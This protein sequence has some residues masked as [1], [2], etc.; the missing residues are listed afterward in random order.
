MRP[1]IRVCVDRPLAVI[2]AFC[3]FVLAGVAAAPNLPVELL[4]NLKSPQIEILTTFANASAQEVESLLTRPVEEAVSA[5]AG[6]RSIRSVSSEGASR[7]IL[8]F[9]WGADISL[10]SAEVREKL[11]LIADE[12]PKESKLP[13][14]SQV[15]ATEAPIVTLALTGMDAPDTVE[16]TTA[17]EIKAALEGLQGV[18]AAHVSGAPKREVVVLI[19]QSRLAAHSLDLRAVTH[20]LE[21]ANINFP[22]GKITKG[23][24]ETS[25]RTVGRFTTLQEIEGVSVGRGSEGGTVRLGDI[26]SVVERDVERTAVCRVN[27]ESAVLINVFKERSANTVEIAA[28][29]LSLLDSIR[30]G[31]PEKTSVSVIRNDAPFIQESIAGLRRNMLEGAA[32]AFLLLLVGLRSVRMS[33]LVMIAIPVSALTTFAAMSVTGV[34]LNIMSI[35][36]IALGVGMLVDCSVVTLQNIHRRGLGLR[37]PREAIVLGASEVAPSLLSG[38]VTILLA[39]SPLM[40]MQGQTQRLFRDF[41]FT[42][43]VSLFASLL[44]A[45][46]LLPALLTKIRGVSTKKPA[47]IKISRFQAGYRRL[48]GIG[49]RYPP[50]FVG[51]AVSIWGCAAYGLAGRPIDLLPPVNVGEF[52][53]LAQSP[54]DY[55]LNAV[56]K[57]VRKVDAALK[58]FPDIAQY[59]T[60]LGV[61]HG[62]SGGKEAHGAGAT[63][64]AVIRVKLRPS[65]PGFGDPG[66]LTRRIAQ[67]V[68]PPVETRL[69]FSFAQG[70]FAARPGNSDAQEVMLIL[71]DDPA[72]LRP[73]AEQIQSL[74]EVSDH[75]RNVTTK[76]AV[77]SKQLAVK[78][79]RYQAAQRGV[80]AKDLAGGVRTAIEGTVVGKFLQGAEEQDIR[81]RL[82]TG[83]DTS[84]DELRTV[85]FL[86]PQEHVVSLGGVAAIQQ[87]DGPREIRHSER[88]CSVSVHADGIGVDRGAA[89][90]IA[91]AL[92]RNVSLAA[93]VSVV[94]GS[95]RLERRAGFQSL[96]SAAF[97]AAA[98]V[99]A[100]L[101]AQFESLKRPLVIFASTPF[102]IVGPAVAL[103]W[104][105]LPVSALT[106]IGMIV[107]LGIV[108]NNAILMVTSISAQRIRRPMTAKAIIDGS[109]ARLEPILITTATTI[110]G[111]APICLS[112]SGAAS[113]HRSLAITVASGVACATIFTLLLTPV[114]YKLLAGSEPGP[115]NVRS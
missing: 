36:G 97:V 54:P 79:D 110:L 4:P 23:P 86:T 8:Q 95:D 100:L 93:G 33:A 38:A 61:D 77:W 22:G 109:A 32:L 96:L 76:G 19:D 60:T 58:Q 42:L 44:T 72:A 84:L 67:L 85:P 5:V 74:L 65:S 16:S 107:L 49:L 11:D 43:A 47:P 6:V 52:T 111:A 30:K 112:T 80:S 75:L 12:F 102:I 114:F 56:D 34:S 17:K 39:L 53:I 105:D 9:D 10:A 63:N 64:E 69:S 41:A 71:S 59:V 37:E 50:V 92:V 90:D 35:G 62:R 7:V 78:I 3:V 99:Y 87:S 45:T 66:S 82:S 89:E 29:V 94:P 15:D 25:V 14:V 48:L 26:A 101:V 73:V 103:Y 20:T 91:F 104:L 2:S 18:A 115:R 70:A 13:V 81:V 21:K 113:L 1:L 108:V 55:T 88:K 106:L 24:L 57:T 31:L 83:A 46:L 51:V 28:A 68:G 40:V 98:L 27:G